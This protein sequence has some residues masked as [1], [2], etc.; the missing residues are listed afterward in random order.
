MEISDGE[1]AKEW[2]SRAITWLVIIVGA[3]VVL[4]PFFWMVS[5][6]LK[7]PGQV[8]LFPP[9]WI[10][11]PVK[12]SNFV[13]AW[14]ASPFTLYL[15]NT[16]VITSLSMLGTIISCALVAFSFS[17]LRW[18]GR[19]IC[20]FLLLCTMMLPEQVTMIPKYLLW[21]R[22]G[23]VNTFV[24][25]I[26]PCYLTGFG[27]AFF[28]FLLRQ[29][30]ATIPFELDDAARIDGCSSFKIFYRI[31]LPLA[32]PGLAV[33]AIFSFFDNWRDFLRPL[34]YID[35]ANKRTLALAIL[36]FRSPKVGI[37]NYHWL[38]AISLIT[39]LPC[40]IVFVTCQ[41]YFVRGIHLTGLK[42]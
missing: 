3:G 8:F 42:G 27:G 4:L 34:I 21:G 14:T 5:T 39:L 22:L 33:V 40:I 18:P 35:S 12:W 25:L 9:K 36:A 23:F 30:F 37:S 13:E 26:A 19:N 17:R 15:I 29:F 16:S 41:R 6:S 10:P 1:K 38:M 31:V 2:V 11:N 24:P 20:F 28:I 7:T 32:K